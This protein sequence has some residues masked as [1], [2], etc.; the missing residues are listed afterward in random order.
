MSLLSKNKHK[1]AILANFAQERFLDW[2][3]LVKILLQFKF[4]SKETTCS[5]FKFE[6]KLLIFNVVQTDGL[7]L[8]L[9]TCEWLSTGLT[10]SDTQMMRPVSQVMTNKKPSAASR[11]KCFNSWSVR[12]DGLYVPSVL[13]FPVPT[14]NTCNEKL[15]FNLYGLEQSGLA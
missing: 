4:Y 11:I 10:L 7:H 15:C 2:A 1:S 13:V 5:Q 9:H 3:G 8:T 6:I 12:N 14:T